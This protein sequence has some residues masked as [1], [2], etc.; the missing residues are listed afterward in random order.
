MNES[1]NCGSGVDFALGQTSG[2]KRET[3]NS[4]LKKKKKLCLFT[5]EREGDTESQ[6]G[7]RLRGVSTEPKA[8]LKPTNCE[9]MT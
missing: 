5:F 1:L 2:P 7:S 4:P 8:E 3:A 6:T 9:I